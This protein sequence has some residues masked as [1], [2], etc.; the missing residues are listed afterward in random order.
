MSAATEQNN[1]DVAVEKI[2]ADEVKE[3]LKSQ[4]PAVDTKSADNGTASKNDDATD[5]APAKEQVKGTKRP[6]DVSPIF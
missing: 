6:S 5:A 4:K 1:G 3:D 2:S